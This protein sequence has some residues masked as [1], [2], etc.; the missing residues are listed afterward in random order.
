MAKKNNYIKVVNEQY[1]LPQNLGAGLIK[2]EAW[3]LD[4]E[5]VKYNMVYI[6]KSIY[7][8]DNGRVLGYDN[9]HNFHHKH[10]FGEIFEL[11]DFINYQ[12][13][14]SRF[15]VDIKEFVYDRD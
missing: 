2:F 4:N 14:V 12:D 5:I 9:A 6:N 11:D 1:V 8:N 13:L 3:E 7:P 10:Y 15:K